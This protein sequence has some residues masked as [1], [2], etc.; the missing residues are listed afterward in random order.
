[1]KTIFSFLLFSVLLVLPC[2]AQD[3]ANTINAAIVSNLNRWHEA[4]AQA[5]FETYFGLMTPDAIYIGTDATEHWDLEAFK[6][7]AKP[8]FDAGKAWDFKAIDRHI[9]VYNNNT[10]AW[11]DE[12]L[13]THMGICRGSGVMKLENGTWKVAHYVLSMTVPNS[14][15]QDVVSVKR[16]DDLNLLKQYKQ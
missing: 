15:M 3:D 16:T 11:F 14:K 2:Q 6:H 10:L 1:M 9:F 8:Y 4:A 5:D 7:F 13:N 12:L